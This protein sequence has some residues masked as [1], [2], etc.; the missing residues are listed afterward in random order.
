M[1]CA[2]MTL[3][4]STA[5]PVRRKMDRNARGG[6][7][8]TWRRQHRPPT[9]A[10]ASS[11]AIHEPVRRAAK[12]DDA[13]NDG[14]DQSTAHSAA[15][16][17]LRR[18]VR[19]CFSSGGVY[20]CRVGRCR[21]G[22]GRSV[23]WCGGRVCRCSCGIGRRS[24]RVSGC[25]RGVSRCCSRIGGGFGRGHVRRCR[26]SRDQR[27]RGDETEFSKRGHVGAFPLLERRLPSL[28]AIG[29]SR[30]DSFFTVRGRQF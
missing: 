8:T 17:G 3:L 10:G 28:T 25:R 9:H 2:R 22:G 27:K 20:G 16:R 15:C 21:V 30:N 23:R 19:R 6:G 18:C 13:A 1:H 4:A 12:Y 5:R 26:Q 7:E 14:C 11:F 24:G 29:L